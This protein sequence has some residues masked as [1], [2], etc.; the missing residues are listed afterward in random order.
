M[1]EGR[2]GGELF[3]T[4]RGPC[5]RERLL[6]FI[7]GSD[8]RKPSVRGEIKQLRVGSE[9]SREAMERGSPARPAGAALP[10][11]CGTAGLAGGRRGWP[12][13]CSDLAL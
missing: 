9:G 13:L 11:E 2:E 8:S 7:N 3:C 4:F 10:G 12:A 5:S 6:S 1:G